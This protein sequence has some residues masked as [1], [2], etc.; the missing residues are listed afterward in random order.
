MSEVG[1]SRIGESASRSKALGWFTA[2]DNQG[3]NMKSLSF[4]FLST[5]AT[6]VFVSCGE[7]SELVTDDNDVSSEEE[8]IGTRGIVVSGCTSTTKPNRPTDFRITNGERWRPFRNTYSIFRYNS[9]GHVDLAW[10]NSSTNPG[11]GLELWRQTIS[12]NSGSYKKIADNI[13]QG[14]SSYVDYASKRF[15]YSYKLRSYNLLPAG[16]CYS[17]FTKVI[18]ILW[19]GSF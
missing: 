11:D 18:A 13:R 15:G 9:I 5:M 16:R 7:L 10:L 14:T 3:V 4:I 19:E 1:C 17:P 2:E 6:I 12:Q 8:T